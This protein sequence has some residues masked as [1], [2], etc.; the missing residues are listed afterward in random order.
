MLEI[1]LLATWRVK[2]TPPLPTDLPAASP[3]LQFYCLLLYISIPNVIIT[4]TF[5][6]GL[7]FIFI[8]SPAISIFHHLLARYSSSLLRCFSFLL[9]ILSAPFTVFICLFV[10]FLHLLDFFFAVSLSFFLSLLSILFPLL[11]ILFL[12]L[13][14]SHFTLCSSSIPFIIFVL[15]FSP[16]SSLP[17]LSICSTLLFF[18]FL[19][20]HLSCSCFVVYLSPAS[21]LLLAFNLL[22]R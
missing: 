9:F 21:P 4:H 19:P 1:K 7:L 14:L 20:F 17:L 22:C 2:R 11:F 10:P 6:S 16:S 15:V 18:T 8:S 5:P 3:P 12:S 13:P